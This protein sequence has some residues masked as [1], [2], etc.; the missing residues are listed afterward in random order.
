MVHNDN[1]SNER[2]SAICNKQTKSLKLW[3]QIIQRKENLSE[4]YSAITD[5]TIKRRARE[6]NMRF[7]WCKGVGTSVSIIT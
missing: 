2:N 1:F 3:Q 4:E 7:N 5:L 6:I